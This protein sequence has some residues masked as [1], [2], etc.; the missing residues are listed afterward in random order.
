[1][2]NTNS[3]EQNKYKRDIQFQDE[4]RNYYL[5]NITLTEIAQKHNLSTSRMRNIFLVIHFRFMSFLENIFNLSMY[6]L[7]HTILK[8]T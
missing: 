7:Y 2:P 1:M 8:G 3:I 6:M 4:Y 5:E